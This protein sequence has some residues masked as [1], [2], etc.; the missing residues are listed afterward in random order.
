[1]L[2]AWWLRYRLWSKSVLFKYMFKIFLFW[3][4]GYQCLW[5]AYCMVWFSLWYS[6]NT[7]LMFVCLLKIT[8]YFLA[9]FICLW[10][11]EVGVF[12]SHKTLMWYS[13]LLEV[14]KKC[15]IYL[16][17]LLYWRDYKVWLCSY[18]LSNCCCCPLSSGL[19]NW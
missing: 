13:L 17:D 9:L 14:L 16:R 3:V 1:M 19:V 15:E 12:F 8:K 18:K 4:G 7:R 5:C 6:D 2:F 11:D 10:H